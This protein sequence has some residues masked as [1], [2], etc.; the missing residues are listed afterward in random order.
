M[1]LALEVEEGC[2]ED[3]VTNAEGKD[4][5]DWASEVER[6]MDDPSAGPLASGSLAIPADCTANLG[7]GGGRSEDHPLL[8]SPTFT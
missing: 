1:P 5:E 6:G 2:V 4:K 3:W 7:S 8:S